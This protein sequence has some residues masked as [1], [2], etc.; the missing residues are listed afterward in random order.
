[1]NKTI[2]IILLV[3][4]MASIPAAETLAELHRKGL[5]AIASEQYEEGILFLRSI[6]LKS[7]RSEYAESARYYAAYFAQDIFQQIVEFKDFLEMFPHSKFAEDAYYFLSMN[8]YISSNFNNSRYY[9]EQY[10]WNYPGGKYA[11]KVNFYLGVIAMKTGEDDLYFSKMS[12]LS[13]Q[14]DSSF[15]LPSIYHLSIYYSSRGIDEKVRDAEE[16]LKGKYPPMVM[17]EE[18]V[19]NI[20]WTIQLGAFSKETGAEIYKIEM[21]EAGIKDVFV[22]KSGKYYKVYS[23]RFK[24]RSDAKKKLKK[25]KEK[26]YEGRVIKKEK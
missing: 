10:L 8:Y 4:I 15:Y 5:E 12:S 19:E 16:I 14:P 9:L 23:G 22:L 20:F 7:P 24:N 3:I 11:D 1:M 26:G 21:K 6:Y 2:S 18:I 25:I 17:I 13:H